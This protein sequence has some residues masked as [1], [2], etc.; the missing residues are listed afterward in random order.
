MT[1]HRK[2]RG[3]SFEGPKHRDPRQQPERGR[4]Q[5]LCFWLICSTALLIVACFLISDR[6]YKNLSRALDR[7]HQVHF[8]VGRLE[9]AQ[10]QVYKAELNESWYLDTGRKKYWVDAQAAEKKVSDE[11][12]LTKSSQFHNPLQKPRI[13]SIER[14]W[15]RRLSQLKFVAQ[16]G[17]IRKL[18]KKERDEQRDFRD[19]FQKRFMAIRTLIESEEMDT[20]DAETRRAKTVEE[21]SELLVSLGSA[22]SIILLGILDIVL[23]RS[24][25][26]GSPPGLHGKHFE[27]EIE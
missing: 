7:S 22:L 5:R 14:M 11:I 13:Q 23:L 15:L 17:I 25:N 4:T 24:I 16:G 10:A 20:L 3:M 18:N 27:V 12:E 21:H 26:K 19:E 1:N 6:N 8:L 9:V 2:K